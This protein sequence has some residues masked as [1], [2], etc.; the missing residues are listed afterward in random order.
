M[1]IK[2]VLHRNR[3]VDIPCYIDEKTVENFSKFTDENAFQI[4]F[5]EAFE[6]EDSI[7]RSDAGGIQISIGLVKNPNVEDPLGWSPIMIAISSHCDDIVQVLA[8][9]IGNSNAKI[10]GLLSPMEYAILLNYNEIIKLLAP[11]C[12]HYQIPSQ[13]IG[14]GLRYNAYE[15]GMSLIHMAVDCENAEA[16]KILAPFMKTPNAP[17]DNGTTPIQMATRK[18]GPNHD[19]VQILQTFQ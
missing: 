1:Y 7:Q 15:S 12:D 10:R 16:I 2:K 4:Y 14:L 17:S 3:V 19:I 11:F 6:D 8:P 18:F 13:P 9:F 5:E